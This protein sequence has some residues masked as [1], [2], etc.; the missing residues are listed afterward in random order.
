MDPYLETWD[1]RNS[2]SGS[3]LDPQWNTIRDALGYTALYASKLDLEHAVP[4]PSLCSTGYCL[5]DPGHQY[6]V[7][8]PDSG[9]FKL[10]VAAGTYRAE[11][12]DPVTGQATDGGTLV[13]AG[14]QSF[15]PPAS[16]TA[17]AV[18]LLLLA[19]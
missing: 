7:Y 11:W 4:S 12:F 9:G 10:T 6:L 15:T 2:P 8:Q 1:I 16:F 5:A 17:D 18:L 14:Q 3:T 13:G 19:P